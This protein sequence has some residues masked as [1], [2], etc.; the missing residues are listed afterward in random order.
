LFA[1]V[2]TLLKKYYPKTPTTLGGG[3]DKKGESKGREKKLL[4]CGND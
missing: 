3:N 1:A 4:F 2:H